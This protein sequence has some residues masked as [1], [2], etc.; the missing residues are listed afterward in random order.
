MATVFAFFFGIALGY[1][2]CL[3]ISE[4]RNMKGW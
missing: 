4:C 1:A 3:V 2:L